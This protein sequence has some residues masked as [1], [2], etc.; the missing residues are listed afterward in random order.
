MAHRVTAVVAIVYGA[1]LSSAAAVGMPGTLA[2]QRLLDRARPLVQA[3]YVAHQRA[4]LANGAIAGD[5]LVNQALPRLALL[6]GE[7]P[8]HFDAELR[9]RY[10]DVAL[11]LAR[12]G[13]IVAST[14][15]AISNLQ[16]HSLDFGQADSIPMSGV[17]VVIGAIGVLVLGLGL[18][19]LGAVALR[20]RHLWPLACIFG[21]ALVAG[22]GTLAVRLPQKAASA[23]AM[24]DS[25][26]L[27]KQT[28]TK[29]RADFTVVQHFHDQ[30]EERLIPDAA[31]RVHTTPPIMAATITSGL[32]ALK[33]FEAQYPA[34]IQSFAPD[35][36]LREASVDDFQVVKR[37][38]MA[39]VTW[40]FVAANAV[41]A[42]VA[43][44]AL[45]S[46]RRQ[47]EGAG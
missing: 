39:A 1:V 28:A 27:S 13:D 47:S 46:R 5:Q 32:G 35:V 22:A 37:V 34:L 3:P 29:T 16:N 38:P 21:V 40:I 44:T 6:L 33:S 24:L 19:A 23:A 43:G 12:R 7:T 41:L 20:T 26:N 31:S 11:G 10:P 8:S 42:A 45:L 30:L 14:Q 2:G 18:F 4:G 15:H 17:P 25:L 9:S 36:A